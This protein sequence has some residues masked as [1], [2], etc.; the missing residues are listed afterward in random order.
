M[1][2]GTVWY[3]GYHGNRVVGI[4]IIYNVTIHSKLLGYYYQSSD[5]IN[6]FIGPASWSDV[7]VTAVCV[8]VCRSTISD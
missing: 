8:C 5:Y 7:V 6:I 1:A 2:M 3:Y 4:S